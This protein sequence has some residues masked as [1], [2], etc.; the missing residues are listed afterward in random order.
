M[1]PSECK[2]ICVRWIFYS[3]YQPNYE[4]EVSSRRLAVTRRCAAIFVNSVLGKHLP[5]DDQLT[6]TLFSRQRQQAVVL[7]VQTHVKQV[8]F[9]KMVGN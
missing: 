3:Q 2:I 6:H 7:T 9:R 5:P 1:Q 4:E 8:F